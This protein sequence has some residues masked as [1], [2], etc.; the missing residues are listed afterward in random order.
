MRRTIVLFHLNDEL[1]Y[2]ELADLAAKPK[3]GENI[4]LEGHRYQV[5]EVH[6]SIGEFKVDGQRRSGMDKLLEILALRFDD[7]AI[8]L[9]AR[10]RNVGS[11]DQ[12][13][14]TGSI[15]LPTSTLV[16]DFDH[17]VLAVLKPYGNK[18]TGN[19]LG[20]LHQFAAGV[21]LHAEP[22]TNGAA[23]VAPIRVGD[24]AAEPEA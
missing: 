15:I 8:P 17:A 11:G 19:L 6:E 10:L 22:D 14:H 16:G 7:Q 4:T 12:P 18:V 1:V 21:P 2:L 13:V 20:Q 3:N 24:A 9:L 5:S 23:A